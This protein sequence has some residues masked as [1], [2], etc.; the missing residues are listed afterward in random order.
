MPVAADPAI[1]DAELCR[2]DPMTAFAYLRTFV[3]LEFH[4]NDRQQSATSRHSLGGSMKLDDVAVR[5]SHKEKHR[6]VG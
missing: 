3:D 1:V 6:P 2:N 5:I 4:Q